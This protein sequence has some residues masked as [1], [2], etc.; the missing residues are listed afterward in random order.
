MDYMAMAVFVNKTIFKT[1]QFVI[2][3]TS[4]CIKENK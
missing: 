3:I 1:F 2:F 4:E